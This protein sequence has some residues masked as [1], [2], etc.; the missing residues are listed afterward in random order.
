MSLSFFSLQG[1]FLP[2]GDTNAY[3]FSATLAKPP[4]DSTLTNSNAWLA[5][6][7]FPAVKL[8]AKPI[9]PAPP[10]PVIGKVLLPAAVTND[11]TSVGSVLLEAADRQIRDRMARDGSFRLDNVPAGTWGLEAEVLRNGDQMICVAERTFEI[12]EIPGGRADEPLD[13]GDVGACHGSCAANRRS[14]AIV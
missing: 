3:F 2:A 9:V 5:H 6:L 8:T 12:P 4:T 13:L 14:C 7:D 10:G 1:W 11:R